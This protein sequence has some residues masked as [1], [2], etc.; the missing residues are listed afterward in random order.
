MESIQT[1]QPQEQDIHLEDYFRIL[2]WNKWAILVIL[3]VAILVTLLK[4]DLSA[5]LYEAKGRIW[6][7][8]IHQQAMPFMADLAMPGLG[9][10]VQL[11]T[12]SEILSTRTIVSS[13]VQELKAEGLLEPLPVHRGKITT[14]IAN[15]LGFQLSEETELGELT[16]EEWEQEV[17]KNLID[18]ALKVEPSRDSDIITIR[19]KQRTPERAQNFVNK[20]ADVFQRFIRKDM[21]RR[22]EAT[23]QFANQQLPH[24]RAELEFAEDQ[25]RKFQVENKTINLDA[26]A[27]MIIQNVGQLDL[28]RVQLLQ[29]YEGAKARLDALTE[30]LST[31]SQKIIS[32][33]VLTDNPIVVRLEQQLLEDQIQ[34]ATLKRQYPG[35]QNPQIKNLI[36]RIAQTKKE[37]SLEDRRRVTSQTTTSNPLHQGLTQQVI[38]ILAEI[39]Q[40]S[41]QRQV[42]DQKIA[43]YDKLIAEWPQKKLELARL[44]RKMVLN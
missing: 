20:I 33:E 22:L 24:T 16:I 13:A 27:A 44:Q 21:Q 1:T 18:S 14:W 11:K 35:H 5:P 10:A 30:E 7:Q 32:T 42:L 31:V 4:N 41:N 12:F 9:R 25:F 3:V 39:R 40:T 6:V 26:E 15:L 23:E 29:Q 2:F 28:Q 34:L 36:A 17:T 37:I 38:E 19:V 43:S 8:E